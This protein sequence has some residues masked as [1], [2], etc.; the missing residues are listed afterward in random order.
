[1]G[2]PIL[3]IETD[4]DGGF[5]EKSQVGAV[6]ARN[7]T[8]RLLRVSRVA[9]Q[10]F[11]IVSRLFSGIEVRAREQPPEFERAGLVVGYDRTGKHSVGIGFRIRREMNDFSLEIRE[12]RKSGDFGAVFDQLEL[13][14]HGRGV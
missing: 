3:G 5:F 2:F 7:E 4:P 11:R 10:E 14:S 12:G 9:E 13:L 1:M 6:W 8:M